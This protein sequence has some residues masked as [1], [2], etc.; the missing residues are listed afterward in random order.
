MF[1]NSNCLGWNWSSQHQIDSII[2]WNLP[3]RK[4]LD[5]HHFEFETSRYCICR[6]VPWV[7]ARSGGNSALSLSDISIEPSSVVITVK[8]KWIYIHHHHLLWHSKL[9]WCS[10][11]QTDVSN[12]SAKR[13]LTVPSILATSVFWYWKIMENLQ[14][15]CSNA[16]NMADVAP[17]NNTTYTRYL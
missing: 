2:L 3:W 10:K 12:I 9:R 17:Y 1:T 5:R 16:I 8:S 13:L 4:Q 6:L 15:S 7:V 14:F 11:V